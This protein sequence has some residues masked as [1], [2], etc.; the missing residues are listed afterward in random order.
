MSL[1]ALECVW[2]GL[3][4]EDERVLVSCREG[5]IRESAVMFVQEDVPWRTRADNERIGHR[6][7]WSCS[8]I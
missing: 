2:V 6:W 1:Q 8:S 7:E 5:Q 3:L 4:S